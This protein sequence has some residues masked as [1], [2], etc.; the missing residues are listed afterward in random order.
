MTEQVRGL[1]IVSGFWDGIWIPAKV[2]GSQLSVTPIPGDS[3][4]LFWP[5][6]SPRVHM[7]KTYMLEK[8]QYIWTVKKNYFKWYHFN[9]KFVK[10]INL[11]FIIFNVKLFLNYLLLFHVHQCLSVQQTVP[12][13]CRCQKR[14]SDLL[15]LWLQMIVS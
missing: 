6:R 14:A 13:T 7:L 4:T 15:A 12:G 8:H 2:H 1:A 10:F 3:P 11:F 5:L 9:F